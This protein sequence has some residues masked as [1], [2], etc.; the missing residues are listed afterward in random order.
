MQ[1]LQQLQRPLQVGRSERAAESRL[2]CRSDELAALS[3]HVQLK[4]G[5][6]SVGQRDFLS[7]QRASNDVLVAVSYQELFGGLSLTV[8]FDNRQT[9]QMNLSQQLN[10]L[11]NTEKQSSGT[12][13]NSF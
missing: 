10:M 9:Q 3:Q 8:Q 11:T 6:R 13:I 4:L 5:I 12:H 2:A 7:E 1:L